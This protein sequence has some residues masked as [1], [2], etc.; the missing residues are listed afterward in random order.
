MFDLLKSPLDIEK[1]P[2]FYMKDSHV[3]GTL[4]EEDPEMDGQPSIGQFLLDTSSSN[5]SLFSYSSCLKPESLLISGHVPIP[6]PRPKVYIQRTNVPKYFAPFSVSGKHIQ[7]ESVS[8]LLDP[9]SQSHVLKGI[10]RVKNLAFEKRV[11]LRFTTNNWKSFSERQAYF[12]QTFESEDARS[13]YSEDQFGFKFDL[14]DLFFDGLLDLKNHQ[15]K[16]LEELEGRVFEFAL[17]YEVQGAL[18]W[19]NHENLN[20]E[21]VFGCSL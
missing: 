6:T 15:D 8:L 12:V 20:Y 19:D 16:R 11:F 18:Y 3:S 5:D 14:N 1:C 2:K 9:A 17:R 4:G 7:V 10:I 13:T 21:V